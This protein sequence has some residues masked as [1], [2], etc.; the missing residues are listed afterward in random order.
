MPRGS[1]TGPSDG[2][3]AKNMNFTLTL[4]AN[5]IWA[6]NTKNLIIINLKY[7][8]ISILYCDPTIIVLK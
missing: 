2:R 4:P 7:Q 8:L 6:L 3:E 1:R 5:F